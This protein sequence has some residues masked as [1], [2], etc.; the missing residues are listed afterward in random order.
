MRAAGSVVVAIVACVDTVDTS[1]GPGPVEIRRSARRRR[2]VSARREG[3]KTVVLMPAGLSAAEEQRLVDQVVGRLV[4]SEQRAAARSTRS[5]EELARRA[6]VLSERWL[7]G[8]ARPSSVRWVPE[9]RTR[10]GSAT[11]ASGAIRISAAVAEFP[12]Y[13]LDYLLVHELAH[14]VVPGGHTQQFW[15][16]VERFPRTERARGYLEA[17]AHAAGQDRAADCAPPD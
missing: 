10:W 3:E 12:D 8:R 4:R 14:L 5:D 2:T 9:M 1:P 6:Q 17:R 13:V 11:P 16:E 15:R 7:G